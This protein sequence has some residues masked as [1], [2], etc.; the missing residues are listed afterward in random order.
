MSTLSLTDGSE[1]FQVTVLESAPGA[2]VLLF[3]VGAG[4][5]PERHLPLLTSLAESGYSVVAPHFTGLDASMP[6]EDELRLWAR[7]LTLA[8]D[9]V[10][11]SGSTVV[12]VGHSLGA[13]ALL[14]LAGGQIWLGAG[15]HVE[16]VPDGRL[17][18]LVLLTPPMG[19]FQVEGALD[20]V[21]TPILAWAGSRDSITPAAQVDVLV[22]ALSGRLPLDVRV[23]EGAGH[24]SFMDLPPPDEV[25]P[26]AD[27]QAFL[28]EL[29]EEVGRF[30]KR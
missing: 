25:E 2:P 22:R 7:R 6:R 19:F 15:R 4:G 13:A 26:L 24:F 23:T 21:Q 27:R 11:P 12:G 20:A 29:A 5:N 8:L 14:A 1:P 9:S 28:D 30:L 17:T 3:A 16:I 10:A 18:R